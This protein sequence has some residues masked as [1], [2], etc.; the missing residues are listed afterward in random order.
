VLAR[1]KVVA[2]NSPGGLRAAL[3]VPSIEAAIASLTRQEPAGAV[4]Q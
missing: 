2:V 1:G 4:N 3:G